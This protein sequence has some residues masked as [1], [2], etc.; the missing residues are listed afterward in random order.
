MIMPD[1]ST[2]QESEAGADR[3]RNRLVSGSSSR[4]PFSS[5]PGS[6]QPSSTHHSLVLFLGI[7][8]IV[9][10][11]VL[12]GF[13]INK[14]VDGGGSALE[15]IGIGGSEEA[16]ETV[17]VTHAGSEG[18]VVT[19]SKPSTPPVKASGTSSASKSSSTGVPAPSKT[20]GAESGSGGSGTFPGLSRNGIGIGEPF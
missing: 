7:A 12:G 8:F 19:S 17:T 3:S 4:D 20:G 6:T 13:A 1:C 18:V 14:Y 5:A 15:G 2:Y 10:L 11:T 16:V 9:R